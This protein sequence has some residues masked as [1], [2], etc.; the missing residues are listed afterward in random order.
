[1]S[2][3]PIWSSGT[4]SCIIIVNS[5]I[6]LDKSMVDTPGWC[7]SADRASKTFYDRYTQLEIR[8]NVATQSIVEI[9]FKGL[10]LD[11]SKTTILMSP[12]TATH[13][14]AKGVTQPATE[15]PRDLG[16]VLEE[17]EKVRA[18]GAA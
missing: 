10:P 17:R 9:V 6:V 16:W 7:T 3:P 18:A 2:V 12:L 5:V 13:C 14:F 15:Y 8:V 11:L 1:M 4:F